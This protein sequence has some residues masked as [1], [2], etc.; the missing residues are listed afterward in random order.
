V[1][2][3]AEKKLVRCIRGALVDVAVDI[4]PSSPT[5]GRHV[6]VELT[7]ENRRMLYIPEGC[8]HGFLTLA[9]E[10]EVFYQMS[11]DYAPALAR[12]FRWN[13]PAFGIDWPIDVAVIADRDRTYP[14]FDP[15]ASP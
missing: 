9:D 5:F 13:D 10:T 4:R 7:A 8:A 12:G 15:G 2:P 14:D 3:S 1:A 6:S 11:A